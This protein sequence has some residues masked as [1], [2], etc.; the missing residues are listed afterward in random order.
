MTAPIEQLL[1]DNGQIALARL[2]DSIMAALN[3]IDPLLVMHGGTAIWRCYNG[4]RFSEDI[5]IYANAAQAKRLSRELTWALTRQ[6]VKM[7]YHNDIRIVTVFN[8]TARTKIEAMKPERRIN[9]VQREYQ[10]ADGT[11]LIITTLSIDD[12]I[13]EKLRTYEKRRYERDLYDIYHLTSLRPLSPMLKKKIESFLNG[14]EQPLKE[15]GSITGLIS[16]G[17]TPTFETMVELIKKRL[18]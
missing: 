13:L 6:N 5:D 7:E 4:N 17:A 12:F 9:P 18:E 3:K 8:E 11:T 1:T 16:A 10:R 2:Q 14:I 15:K